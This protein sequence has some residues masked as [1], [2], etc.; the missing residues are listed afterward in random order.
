MKYIDLHTHSKYSGDSDFSVKEIIDCAI[1]KKLKVIAITD[2]NTISG[3]KEA[4][5]YFN[6]KI[7]LIPGIEIS[8]WDKNLE[9]IDIHVLGLFIDWKNKKLNE[10]YYKLYKRKTL[11]N[12]AK[13]VIESNIRLK[14]AAKLVY[15]KLK[16]IVNKLTKKEPTMKEAIKMIKN[17]GG[18]AILAHPGIYLNKTDKILERFIELGGQ[19]LEVHYP[20]DK[21]YDFDRKLTKKVINKIKKIAVKNK[22]VISGG[23]DF[24][25]GKR[26]VELGDEGLSE[27][28]FE[29]IRKLF[30]KFLK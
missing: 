8:C 26:K 7:I 30:K 15:K 29:K 9:N 3:L 22:L 19:G 16:L 23:S 20:Y 11:V 21:L 14:K 25:G 2:H 1:K 12:I 6:R 27:K 17:A 24:H 4:L 10:L 28:E 18:V 13:F 5:E